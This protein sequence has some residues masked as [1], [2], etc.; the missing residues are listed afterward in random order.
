M[1]MLNVCMYNLIGPKWALK[2]NDL[3][4]FHKTDRK[5]HTTTGAHVTMR[6][7][8]QCSFSGNGLYPFVFNQIDTGHG[9]VTG[10]LT[11]TV[12]YQFV[13]CQD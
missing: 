12:S 10:Q 1:E 11:V 8:D 3:S 13:D 4:I 6:V 2:I 9:V 7:L 5:P